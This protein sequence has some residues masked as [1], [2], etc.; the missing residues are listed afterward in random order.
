MVSLKDTVR[1]IMLKAISPNTNF[2]EMVWNYETQ[3]VYFSA[4]GGKTVIEFIDLF[5][6]TF[7]LTLDEVNLVTRTE[8]FMESNGI[9]LEITDLEQ[10]FFGA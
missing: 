2:Y 1:E 5:Q 4:T 8:S 10:S 6:D 7:S 9:G 3:E